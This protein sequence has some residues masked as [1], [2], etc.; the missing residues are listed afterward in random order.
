M[1]FR[2][3]YFMIVSHKYSMLQFTV[4]IL[5]DAIGN[6]DDDAA[7]ATAPAASATAPAATAADATSAATST[8]PSM[9]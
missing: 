1:K 7:T 6:G 8:E 5:V 9:R 3:Y 4:I 2:I